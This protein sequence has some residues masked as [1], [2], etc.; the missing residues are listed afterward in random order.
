MYHHNIHVH[1]TFIIVFRFRSIAQLIN[2]LKAAHLIN[3]STN[4]LNYEHF[5]DFLR[6]K[7]QEETTTRSQYTLQCAP[8]T[9]LQTKVWYYY[10]NRAG[11]YTPKGQQKRQLKTQGTNKTGHQCSAH[12][13][14]SQD[15]KTGHITVFY[16]SYHHSHE[17]NLA[18]LQIPKDTRLELIRKLQQGV[19]MDRILDDIRE[20]LDKGL[21]RE[22]LVTK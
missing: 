21:G 16:C 6:W 8:Q 13:K 10:C 4:T 11:K 17:T 2:H 5:D 9:S 1:K 19:T 12:M 22:H 7:N 18:H 20:T 14:V 3:I 15:I